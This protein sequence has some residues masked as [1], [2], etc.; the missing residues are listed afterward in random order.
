MLVQK[1]RLQRTVWHIQ[2]RIHWPRCAIMAIDD[3]KGL[4]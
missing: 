4:G 2:W 3:E 1:L